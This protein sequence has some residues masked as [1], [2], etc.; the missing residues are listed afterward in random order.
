MGTVKGVNAI[1]TNPFVKTTLPNARKTTPPNPGD[2]F[3]E[4]K[5][6]FWKG[7]QAEQPFKACVRQ[8]QIETIVLYSVCPTLTVI[9]LSTNTDLRQA[10]FKPLAPYELDSV[11]L[12]A[13]L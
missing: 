7:A 10:L 8:S 3:P 12:K 6:Y 9:N 5:F 1:W 13:G 4:T 2:A 11:F